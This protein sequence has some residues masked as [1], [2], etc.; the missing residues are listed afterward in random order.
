MPHAGRAAAISVATG[1]FRPPPSVVSRTYVL[2]DAEEEDRSPHEP[3]AAR[4]SPCRMGLR[5]AGRGNHRV[6]NRDTDRPHRRPSSPPGTGAT[7]PSGSPRH[8]VSSSSG[9]SHSA[10]DA[11]VKAATRPARHDRTSLTGCPLAVT[12]ALEGTAAYGEWRSVAADQASVRTRPT[13][14]PSPPASVT[15]HPIDGSGGHVR[16]LEQ[17]VPQRSA[18]R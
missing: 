12:A 1:P 2:P 11:A 4:S 8:G 13:T 15:W 10:G 16:T 5:H 6:S 9:M 17:I 18:H 3:R 7:G 14:E